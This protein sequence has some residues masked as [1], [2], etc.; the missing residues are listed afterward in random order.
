MGV[1]GAVGEFTRDADETVDI[2]ETDVSLEAVTPRAALRFRFGDEVRALAVGCETGESAKRIVLAVDKTKL[3]LPVAASLA[4]LG[5][6]V[7]SI[8]GGT[9][10]EH[11][12]DLGLGRT[13]VRFCIRTGDDG[14]INVLDA[15]RG[16]AWPQVLRECGLHLIERSPTRVIETGLGRVE[17]DARIPPPGGA[18]PCGP[19]THLLPD[20]LALERDMP[21]GMEIPEGYAPGAIFYSA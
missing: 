7:N 19:H 6:D 2:T 21:V 12:Y 18:S 15:A 3:R 4:A 20:Y 8:R 11:L 10:E 17:I 9:R 1:V 14:L 16:M 13:A 5:R